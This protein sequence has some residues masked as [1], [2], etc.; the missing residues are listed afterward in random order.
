MSD[1]FMPSFHNNHVVY[2]CPNTF[3]FVTPVHVLQP[4]DLVLGQFFTY[5]H[6]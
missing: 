5:M 4:L 1:G 2:L 6:D 3:H